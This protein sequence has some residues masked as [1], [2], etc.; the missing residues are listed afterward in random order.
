VK[1]FSIV[2]LALGLAFAHQGKAAEGASALQARAVL[3]P[4]VG[5]RVTAIMGGEG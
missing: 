5:S 4:E 1:T 2:L 3:P